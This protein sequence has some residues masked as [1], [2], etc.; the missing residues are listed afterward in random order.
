MTTSYTET[1]PAPHRVSV[2]VGCTAFALVANYLLGR[3]MAS[4]TMS[5]H[6][7]A[8]FNALHDRFAQDYFPAGP[9]SYFNPYIHVPFYLLVRSGLSSLEISS[10]MALAHSA[11][12]WL[13]YELAIVACPSND[14]RRRCAFGLC[15]VA[16]ALI[17]PILLQQIGS[18]FAD[19]TTGELVLA[20]WLLLALSVRAPSS[21]RI[22]GAGLLC[23]I[24]TGFK[25]TNAVH[26]IAGATTLVLLPTNRPRQIRFVLAYG[27]TVAI[28]FLMVAAPWS[29][30][31][32]GRF[33]N[34]L[35]P[36][37]NNLFRSPE[38][39][40]EPVHALRFVPAGIFEGLGRPFAMIDPVVMVHVE[41]RAPDPRYAILLICSGVVVCRW[42]WR[43]H[44]GAS[45]RARL[46]QASASTRVL[47]AL[48]CGLL[49][50]WSVWLTTSGNS[51]YFIPLSSVAAVLLVALLFRLFAEHPKARNYVL[52][53]ILAAQGLQ[54]YMG[55]DYRW[56]PTGWSD[57]W[58]DIELPPKLAL[59]PDLY[60]TLGA[61]SNSFLAPYLAPAA[62][63]INVAGVYALNR[64]GANGARVQ[65]LIHR[66]APNVRMLV[67]GARLY[68]ESEG[69]MPTRAF[70]DDAV[71]SFGLRVDPGDCATI[72]VHGLPP[73]LEFTMAASKPA[74]PQSHDS[75]F[76]VSCRLVAD[77]DH[78]ANLHS[79][80]AVDLALDHLEDA[81]PALFQPRRLRTEYGGNGGL[82]R[83][84]NTDLVAWV[85]HGTVKF[86]QPTLGGG[87]VYLGREDDWTDAAR[88]LRCGRHRGRYFADMVE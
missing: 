30:R 57:H 60:L 3:D 46:R 29:Y 84:L 47:A 59:Q 6:L 34:P 45:S 35:F 83:Y 2:Y 65:A 16:F 68:G 87:T 21:A 17:N 9:Q 75:T 67:A 20:G 52:A 58:V 25:L 74:V 54:L 12:L 36:L 10:I 40:I 37:L 14:G 81:C 62:G 73:D 41:L 56:N 42:L 23:G 63:L 1:L 28:G 27:A 22:V 50:D 71:G 85:S 7:Y 18:T 13:T 55:T 69:R 33:G 11:I 4:D 31:L 51:R 88:T 78:S 38:Y 8:G 5:Y 66:Y 76:L 19:I 72:T 43:R 49:V 86:R 77:D 48:G 39:T 79:R 61:Q 15:A 44:S 53:G 26:A 82:R 80:Q 70:I 64:D 24:A 32:E